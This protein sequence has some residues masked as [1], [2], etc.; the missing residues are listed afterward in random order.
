MNFVSSKKF[1]H[2]HW[3][4]WLY[5][6]SY[7]VVK[8]YKTKNYTIFVHLA[9][10]PQHIPTQYNMLPQHLVF[11]YELNCEY[12]NITLK[13]NKAPWWWS[14]KIETCRSVL[15]C[16]MWNYM[17]IRWLINWCWYKNLLWGKV[18]SS[19]HCRVNW[20]KALKKN[21]QHSKSICCWTFK[22]DIVKPDS[23]VL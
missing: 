19:T 8:M 16:F 4:L 14:D 10:A 1:E 20:H 7:C 6:C 3:R 17:S 13:R 22:P 11:K 15:K 21:L 12:R 18:L 23:D 9:T 2:N 5:C